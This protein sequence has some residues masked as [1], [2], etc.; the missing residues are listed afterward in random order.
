MS[1]SSKKSKAYLPDESELVSA[2]KAG[3]EN[4]FQ[5]LMA[6]HRERVYSIAYGF[7]L[8]REESLDI[9]QEVFIKAFRGIHLFKADS[10]LSTW[11]HR[12]TVN[13]SLNWRRKWSRRFKSFHKPLDLRSNGFNLF[14]KSNDKSPDVL[15]DAKEMG[16]KVKKAMADLPE[17]ARMVF[18]LREVE[19]YSY[20]EIAN[21]LKIRKGTVSSRLH[22]ARKKLQELLLPYLN[23]EIP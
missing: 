16:I 12:I 10:K 15:F 19:G 6:R 3:D 4:A 23:G 21:I 17:Q 11:L 7:T 2:L 14:L 8:D 18:V 1:N 5:I 13:E 9:V 22:Y 20:E